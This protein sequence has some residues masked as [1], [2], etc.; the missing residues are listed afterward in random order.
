[1][2]TNHSSKGERDMRYAVSMAG[3]FL[4]CLLICSVGADTLT[5][6]PTERAAIYGETE[7]GEMEA[8]LLLDFDFS[9]IPRDA[10]ITDASLYFE[11][12]QVPTSIGT[13]CLYAAGVNREWNSEEADW[14]GPGTD[15]EW[16]NPGGD[17]TF[18]LGDYGCLTSESARP[19]RLNLTTMMFR[20]MGE[21][22]AL[23]GLILF[24]LEYP[25][26]S[27][28]L[29]MQIIGRLRPRLEI[30]YRPGPG[31]GRPEDNIVQEREAEVN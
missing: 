12:V 31:I 20:Q 17:W 10:R 24:P 14:N 3:V 2:A 15:A 9:Q 28:D 6:L 21:M 8:R 25:S 18:A 22:E 1:M 29:Q 13:I 16:E 27:V 23:H 7:A 5:L 4:A 19:P 11:G 26:D 30:E